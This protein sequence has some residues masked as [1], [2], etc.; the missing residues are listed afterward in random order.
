MKLQNKIY[1][2]RRDFRVEFFIFEKFP[3]NVD[4]GL[5]RFDND[6]FS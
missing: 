6:V 3:V 1:R 4:K 5:I 2:I